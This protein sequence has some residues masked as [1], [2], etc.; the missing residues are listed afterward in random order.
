MAC[1]MVMMATGRAPKSMNLGLEKVGV[2]LGP[3]GA[4]MVSMSGRAWM[5]PGHSVCAQAHASIVW[6]GRANSAIMVGMSSRAWML[7]G[8]GVCASNAHKPTEVLCGQAG[9]GWFAGDANQPANL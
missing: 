8:R 4:I 7:P 9:P 5:L 1:A 2:S 6:P 3:N